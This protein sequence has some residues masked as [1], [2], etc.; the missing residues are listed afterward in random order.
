MSTTTS[1]PVRGTPRVS[2]G[3]A[4]QYD[5]VAETYDR[6]IRPKYDAIARRV[7][8]VVAAE[9]DLS[10]AVVLELS[11]GTG[12]LTCQLAPLV[13]GGY[14]ATDISAP[15]LEVARRRC[16]AGPPIAWIRAGVDDLG[17][18]AGLADVVTSSLGPVQDEVASLAEAHRVAAPDG[19]LVA[20]T[21]GDDYA[22]LDVMQAARALVGMDPRPVTSAVDLV[23]RARC[24][25][26]RDVSVTPLRLPVSHDSLEAYTAYRCA[27]GA[28]PLPDGLTMT[29]LLGALRTAAA[30]YVDVAGRVVL[31]WHLLVL[32][33]T[34]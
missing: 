9:R 25:G 23:D 34:A 8:E 17:L 26:F 33:A 20:C 22:E 5:D 16:T 1:S 3:S 15:M 6:L 30:R 13:G 32:T 31:D 12:A 10:G 28:M 7:R 29:D 27:F 18:P 21:W 2:I 14:V 4:T 11:V 24:A 19:R